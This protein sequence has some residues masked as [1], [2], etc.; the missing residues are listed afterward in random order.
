MNNVLSLPEQLHWLNQVETWFNII[1]KQ[2]IRCGTFVS[3]PHLIRTIENHIAHWNEDCHPFAWTAT[4]D[5]IMRKLEE[6]QQGL[7]LALANNGRK[8]VTIT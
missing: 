1:T 3:V 7:L 8:R 4:A 6:L 2:S 5:D